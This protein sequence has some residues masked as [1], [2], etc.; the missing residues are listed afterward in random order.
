MH[1]ITVEANLR[2]QRVGEGVDR[3]VERV[4]EG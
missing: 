2:G 1:G 4:C 3:E